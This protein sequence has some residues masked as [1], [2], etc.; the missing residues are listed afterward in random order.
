MREREGERITPRSEV[1]AVLKTCAIGQ[2]CIDTR[3]ADDRMW[4][5]GDLMDL[6]SCLRL[7]DRNVGTFLIYELRENELNVGR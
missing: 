2:S 6:K 7:A 1:T 3:P 5:K 4:K